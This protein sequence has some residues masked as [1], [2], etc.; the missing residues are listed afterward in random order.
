MMVNCPKCGFSQPK[1]RY[2]ASCG[3]DMVAFRPAQKPL[4]TRLLQNT[5]VQIVALVGAIVVLGIYINAQNNRAALAQR[6]AELAASTSPSSTSDE[7]P[8]SPNDRYQQEADEARAA[9]NAYAEKQ[10][11]LTEARLAENDR[12][13]SQSANFASTAGEETT[14]SSSQ[15]A[16]S[17]AASASVAANPSPSASPSQASPQAA[18]GATAGAGA[19]TAEAPRSI[20][21]YFVEIPR[22]AAADLFAQAKQAGGDGVMNFGVISDA[23]G[24]LSTVRGLR[25]IE[26]A[27]DYQIRLNQPAIAF[28]GTHDLQ[29]NQNIGFT[30]QAVP[31]ATEDG[32]VRF[33]IDV[34]R[35]L[36]DPSAGLESFNFMLP[37]SF[38][39]PKKGAALF[40]GAL[41]HR[42]LFEGEAPAYRNSNV[43]R[44]MTSGPFRQG[45]TDVAIV[46]EAK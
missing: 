15:P 7:L 20:Q 46:I 33:Q 45:A 39:I 24:K 30:I 29:T 21:I 37:E 1:D 2:C 41:P 4:M 16:G 3:V 19:T 5:S 44:V 22:A 6:S 43:L 9:A 11:A 35:I 23:Q 32:S 14:S 36:K 34:N 27:G 8:S 28:K 25:R 17:N 18:A 13:S 26:V 40:S 12:V 31:V 38:V 42:P 10:A